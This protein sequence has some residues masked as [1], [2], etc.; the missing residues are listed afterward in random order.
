MEVRLTGS[1]D[2]F[3]AIDGEKLCLITCYFLLRLFGFHV[4]SPGVLSPDVFLQG[5]PRF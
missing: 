4:P 1:T 3:T 5:G 2:W